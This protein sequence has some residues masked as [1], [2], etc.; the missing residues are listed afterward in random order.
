MN[1]KEKIRINQEAYKKAIEENKKLN[2]EVS[3]RN[4]INNIIKAS[5][6]NTKKISSSEDD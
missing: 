5:F 6:K 4:N 1:F 2:V 3:I